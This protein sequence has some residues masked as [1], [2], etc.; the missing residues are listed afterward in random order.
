V[1]LDSD[2]NVNPVL[3]LACVDRE[4]KWFAVT[5]TRAPIAVEAKLVIRDVIPFRVAWCAEAEAIQV[6]AA[7]QL[8]DA[9][10]LF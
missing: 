6:C 9:F 10:C 4:G 7:A 3:V 8:M 1:S 5:L 2:V